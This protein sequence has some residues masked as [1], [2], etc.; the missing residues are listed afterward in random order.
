VRDCATAVGAPISLAMTNTPHTSSPARV[1][2]FTWLALC[3]AFVASLLLGAS[4]APTAEAAQLR[5]P[6]VT[7]LSTSPATPVAGQT[8]TMTFAVMKLGVYYPYSKIACLG[9]V[10]G[11]PLPPLEQAGDGTIAHCSWNIPTTAAGK[12]L[13]GMVVVTLPNGVKYFLG[14]EY[15]IS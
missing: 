9:M 11:R 13:Y 6:R 1:S 7:V 2:R 5:K 3:L 15:A 10:A 12:L 4:T 8:F 14:Y